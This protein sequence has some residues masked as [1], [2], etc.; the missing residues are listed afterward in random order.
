MSNLRIILRTILQIIMNNCFQLL[1]YHIQREERG[2]EETV[3]L[4][5]EIGA[6]FYKKT[7]KGNK[8]T[9][10]EGNWWFITE[11]EIQK[12]I[13]DPKEE[14]ISGS[15]VCYTFEMDTCDDK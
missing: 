1:G 7:R 10:E 13:P 12:T 3:L 5:N 2:L 8:F 4:R 9:L 15:R 14:K 6:L 11:D